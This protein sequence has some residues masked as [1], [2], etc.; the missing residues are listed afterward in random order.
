VEVD[1]ESDDRQLAA[2][3]G[4]TDAVGTPDPRTGL[5]T[6]LVSDC[7]LLRLELQSHSPALPVDVHRKDGDGV[8]RIGHERQSL[9]RY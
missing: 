4:R 2:Y 8:T 5:F 1:V 7:F 9:T 3:P 6:E